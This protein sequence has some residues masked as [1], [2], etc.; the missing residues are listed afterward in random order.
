MS[1]TL[2]DHISRLAA[3]GITWQPLT[4]ADIKNYSNAATV[5]LSRMPKRMAQVAA[6]GWVRH[7]NTAPSYAA[8]SHNIEQAD[9]WIKRLCESFKENPLPVDLDATDDEIVTLAENTAK[10]FYRR[11]FLPSWNLEKQLDEAQRLGVDCETKFDKQF[12]RG[13]TDAILARLYDPKWW[14]RHFR[15]QISRR[16]EHVYRGHCNLVHKRKW[17]YVSN[18]TLMRRQQQ[19]RRNSSLM[20]DVTLINELGETFALSELVARSNANP[21]IR[22]AEL[23]TRIAGFETVAQDLGHCGE[24]ITLTCPSRFHAA[25]HLSGARNAKYDGSTPRD[26]SAYL[27]KVWARIQSALAR[28]KIKVYGFRVVEPH[29]DGCPH[30]HALFFM[31]RAHRQIF[32]KIVARHGCRED[33]EELG[34]SY[35]ETAKALHQHARMIQAKQ[36][37]QGMKPQSL[38]EISGSLKTEQAFWD[39]ADWRVLKDKQVQARVD[40]KAIDWKRGTAAGYIAKYIAKNIDGRNTLGDSVGDD[41]E[42]VNGADVV[43]TAERV[44]AWAAVWGIRQFQQ[45]GGAPVGVWRELRRVQLT[46][47][48]ADMG[49]AIVCAAQAADKGDW[50]KF[51]MIMGG[52]AVSRADCPMQLYKELP[53]GTDGK[54][55]CNA[56]G[57]PVAPVV[58]GVLEAGTGEIRI[59]RIHEWTVVLGKKGGNAAAW[60]CVNNSTKMEFD[61]SSVNKRKEI[62]WD[63]AGILGSLKRSLSLN[64]VHWY[65]QQADDL[66]VQMKDLPMMGSLRKYLAAERDFAKSQM[67]KINSLNRLGCLPSGKTLEQEAADLAQRAADAFADA[68]RVAMEIGQK[69][70]ERSQRAAL[71]DYLAHLDKLQPP[72]WADSFKIRQDKA[73]QSAARQAILSKR[74]H[75]KFALPKVSKVHDTVDSVLAE[76]ADLVDALEEEWFDL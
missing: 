43:S 23:M 48:D 49:A 27:N 28:E 58:R 36:R 10:A 38:A 62:V 66:T 32:R 8:Y 69:E 30:W 39:E 17:L 29:H 16:L 3:H 55:L 75:S 31:E 76:L 56:Y 72:V 44:D 22:R 25:H 12:K 45:V 33:R 19:K 35:F 46:A 11:S 47:D 18:D 13:N 70:M 37:E 57:E 64:E 74:K 67:E 65:E 54:V 24:F 41:F 7:A 51:M 60:T 50:A 2:A 53:C 61:A 71:R 1:Y 9:A 40:F 68:E 20:K 34:L 26:A 52:T 59:S 4:V 5:A 6:S 14:K 42:S 63:F 73:Q 15:S 21:A